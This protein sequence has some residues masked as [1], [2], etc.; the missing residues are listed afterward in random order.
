MHQD[1]RCTP[2]SLKVT[3]E[4]LEHVSAQ[5]IV[6][7]FDKRKDHR[8]I[9]DINDFEIQVGWKSLKSFEDLNE[10]LTDLAKQ[11]CVLVDSYAQQSD[12]Q[13]LQDSW[14]T[15]SARCAAGTTLTLRKE[16]MTSNCIGARSSAGRQ[17]R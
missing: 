9:S 7:A 11:I 3:D 13:R 10:P 12:G 1:I 16:A 5:G 6:L 2:T 17:P 4:L 8:W 14:Q 15:V